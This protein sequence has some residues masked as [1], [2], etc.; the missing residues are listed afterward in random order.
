M[1][2]RRILRDE[3]ERGYGIDDVLYRYEHHV[4]PTYR[5]YVLPGRYESDF[6]IPN[7]SGFE[8]ALEVISAHLKSLIPEEN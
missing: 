6:I 5:Q 8:R 4:M 2:K 3:S 7:E 1:M